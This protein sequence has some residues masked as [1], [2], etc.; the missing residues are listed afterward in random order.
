MMQHFPV[1]SVMLLFLSAFLVEI[2]GSKNATIRNAITLIATTVSLILVA[3]LV[4]SIMVRG[5]IIS[6]WMGNWEP[7]AGYAIGIGFEIDA[8]GLFFALLVAL[9]TWLSAVYS[10]RYMEKDHHLGHYYTL[11]LML[12]GSVLG[13]VMTGDIFNMFVMIEIMTFASV[14]M[15]AFRNESEGALEGAFKYL[16]IGSV[17]SSMNLAGI[18]LLYAECHTLNMA[19]ISSILCGRGLTQTSVMAFALIVA[20][21]GVKSYI[22]PFHTPAA[23]SYAV[24][25]TAASMVFAGMVN[26]A[27]VYG[28]IRTV[29]IVFRA[30]DE[31]TVQML[32]VI[33][34]AVTMF[35]GVTMALAQHE[36]KR[37][38]AYHSIS[39][40]GYVITAIGLGSAL[41][42][43]GGLFHALNHT[44]FKGL[45]FLCA[46]AVLY[47]TGTTDL[48]S[49]G[50]LSKRMPRTT[51]CF[52][53]GAAAIS[54]LP[55]F[56]GFA[57]KWM[58]YQA[59]YE[60]AVSSG[61][62]IYV[63]VT[64]TALVVSVMTLAS[65]VKVTQAVFFG[66]LREE[67]KKVQEVPLS[68]QIPMFIMSALCAFAGIF[69][70]VI[71]RFFLHP[72][73]ESAMHVTKYI[74][75]MMGEGY[76]AA[77][78]AQDISFAPA[79][80]S[81]WDPL[82][83]LALFVMIFAAAVIVIVLGNSDRGE[84]RSG[85]SARD[86]KYATFFSGEEEEFSQVGG[87][88]LFWGFR[89]NWK[90]Y[91]DVLGGIHSGIVTDYTTM[92]LFGIAIFVLF[93]FIFMR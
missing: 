25:P 84:I 64:V 74:D 6:Y 40:I 53:T 90:R 65:F 57:S 39:Q 51:F 4:P 50:G 26:K 13:I 46:G 30:M 41:G 86:P 75:K 77:A 60:K 81:Y 20:G 76:A 48:D 36:F 82:I 2:F 35:V 22:V 19:Q 78:G 29:Y 93:M 42:L 5:E 44:L 52:L 88:D 87:S 11:F 58:I 89:K 18:A 85:S 3:A 33:F 43:T 79:V 59:I 67:H 70:N 68:M 17:G 8:L 14:A 9:T 55:P 66:Q 15:T 73:T 45:L 10:F 72:A 91:Y 69:Y 38:L 92:T 47:R 62:F 12:A 1:L 7:V 34:G 61:K 23:D 37:L 28:L 32:L 80:F 24:A 71:N 31:T 49:L 56:N 27:G 16:V 54:G 21:F 63:I 83:W